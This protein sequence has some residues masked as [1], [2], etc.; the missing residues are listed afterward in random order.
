MFD[1]ILSKVYDLNSSLMKDGPLSVTIMSGIPNLANVFRISLM[2]VCD[3]ALGVQNASIHLEWGSIRMRTF[4]SQMA[5][6]NPDAV[7]PMAW[8]ATSKG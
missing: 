1:S 7:A 8:M 4:Y 6:Q 3:V 2:T 5:P